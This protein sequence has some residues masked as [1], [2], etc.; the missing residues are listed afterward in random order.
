MAKP[1]S[2]IISESNKTSD[3]KDGDAFALAIESAKIKT[4]VSQEQ[5]DIQ[6]S[7]REN[8][9]KNTGNPDKVVSSKTDKKNKSLNSETG[10]QQSN[11]QTS[12]QAQVKI[13]QQDTNKAISIE[14]D[15]KSELLQKTKITSDEQKN[16]PLNITDNIK[17]KQSRSS[18]GQVNIT[19]NAKSKTTQTIINQ[20]YPIQTTNDSQITSD[21]GQNNFTTTSRMSASIL[22]NTKNSIR[23]DHQQSSS[24]KPIPSFG[25][26]S[27]FKN[28]PLSQT[29]DILET[30]FT[31]SFST[32]KK[33]KKSITNDAIKPSILEKNEGSKLNDFSKTT[34]NIKLDDLAKDPLKTSQQEPK[35]GID[36]NFKDNKK[37]TKNDLLTL[38]NITSEK[39]P[40]SNSI[41]SNSIVGQ[42]IDKNTKTNIKKDIIKSSMNQD[43]NIQSDKKTSESV[44]ITTPDINDEAKINQIIDD[45]KPNKKIIEKPI[46]SAI[47]DEQ[48]S[49]SKHRNITSTSVDNKK[50]LDIIKDQT[51][52]TDKKLQ[53]EENLK[54]T[55]KNE[56]SLDL[57][58]KEK[59]E[60]KILK[61]SISTPIT[62]EQKITSKQSRSISKID[63]DENNIGT[64]KDKSFL[65]DEKSQNQTVEKTT[66]RTNDKGLILDDTS[67]LKDKHIDNSLDKKPISISNL[68]EQKILPSNDVLSRTQEKTD[69]KSKVTPLLDDKKSN[70]NST[71]IAPTIADEKPSISIRKDSKDLNKLP[72]ESIFTT[73]NRLPNK[74]IVAIEKKNLATL[75][76]INTDFKNEVK[77]LKQEILND[78]ETQTSFNFTADKIVN[79]IE[80]NSKNQTSP[81]NSFPQIKETIAS[82]KDTKNSYQFLKTLDSQLSASPTNITKD[83]KGKI[84]VQNFDGRQLASLKQNTDGSFEIIKDTG[85]KEELKKNITIA[86]VITAKSDTS[87]ITAKDITPSRNSKEITTSFA[88]YQSIKSIDNFLNNGS[89][90]ELKS[91]NSFTMNLSTHANNEQIKKVQKT[92]EKAE[93]IA[94]T[95]IK[96]DDAQNLKKNAITNKEKIIAEQEMK[97]VQISVENLK[98]EDLKVELAKQSQTRKAQTNQHTNPNTPKS[99]SD[100]LEKDYPAQNIKQNKSVEIELTSQ[101]EIPK[102]LQNTKQLATSDNRNTDNIRTLSE[103]KTPRLEQTKTNSQNNPDI[104]QQ[105]SSNI[106]PNNTQNIPINKRDQVAKF[107]NYQ[108]K[109]KEEASALREINKLYETTRFNNK[110]QISSTSNAIQSLASNNNVIGAFAALLNLNG[111]IKPN[112]EHK[113]IQ[114]FG[115]AKNISVIGNN[116]SVEGI[117]YERLKTSDHVY[118]ATDMRDH[119]SSL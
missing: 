88:N 116:I 87:I 37:P 14:I 63:N 56:P 105:D 25:E 110:L 109:D 76:K 41:V 9:P 11:F 83:E 39:T 92:F 101:T 118:V 61:K 115:V 95:R 79:E 58:S 19:D 111:L 15:Q 22:T 72:S 8:L 67:K 99:Y 50:T 54:A 18:D 21:W 81:Y 35:I 108:T 119:F 43:E 65:I 7:F 69:I 107:N 103:Q 89:I 80:Q 52:T 4:P 82:Y 53:T 30:N 36:S 90:N 44:K 64:A 27:F 59:I 71:T 17:T 12:S 102:H 66:T 20:Q 34:R 1:V 16:E 57:N 49:I 97:K 117:N 114:L 51:F 75:D 26:V 28:P 77:S 32:F 85:L 100:L 78:K 31:D 73:E 104:T 93:L 38:N 2:F 86:D 42:S 62:D 91:V 45:K 33:T 96:F 5:Q 55:I 23:N 3:L 29:K 47:E 106:K 70:V 10:Q 84:S 6:P 60:E 24:E 74:S 68:D 48:K 94:N 13:N 113:R 98:T 46:T 112:V 40:A